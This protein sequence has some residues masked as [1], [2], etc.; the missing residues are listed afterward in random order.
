MEIERKFLIKKLPENREQ[1]PHLEIEQAYLCKEPVV[2][3][4]RE[5]EHYYMTY[6][7]KGLMVR[8]EYNLPLS[9]D[10]YEHLK[11][12]ADGNVIH[13]TRYLIPEKNDLTIEL[14]IFH[15]ALAPLILAEVEFPT[16]EDALSYVMPDWFQEDVTNNPSYHNSNMTG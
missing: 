11:N 3:I 6:K 16:Q 14:D 4:R 10:A 12:K 1:F 13:K 9:Q 5:N 15:D 8:E 7:G 2:R